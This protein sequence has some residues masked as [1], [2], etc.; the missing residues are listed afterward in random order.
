MY[1]MTVDLSRDAYNSQPNP[2]LSNVDQEGVLCPALGSLNLLQGEIGA[3]LLE[4]NLNDQ[5]NTITPA[6]SA[7]RVCVAHLQQ[8][9][10][11]ASR[12]PWCLD[13]SAR[14]SSL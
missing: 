7:L 12:L 1:D 4:V 8:W 11:H 14:A 13:S 5:G 6:A 9:S 10:T 3:V 2:R